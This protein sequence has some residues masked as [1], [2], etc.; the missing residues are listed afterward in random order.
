MFATTRLFLLS[1][2]ASTAALADRAPPDTAA[3]AAQVAQ[4][5]QA[6][7]RDFHAHPELGN[8]EFRTAELVAG[9]LRGLGL[10]VRTGIAHT[11]V[12]GVL[13]GGRPGPRLALRADMDAL[14]VTERVDLPFASK[15]VAEYRGRQT[16]VMHACGH[17]AHTAILMGVAQALTSIRTKLPGEVMFIFQPAEE[18]PPDGEE[19]GAEMML[20]EGLF[21][22]FQPDAVLGLHVIAG[23]PSDTIAVRPGPF[24]AA[25]DSFRIRVIGRQSHGSRPWDGIDPIVAAADII[26]SAQALVSRQTDLTRAP[27]VLSFGAINGGIRSNIIPESVELIGTI[28]TFEPDMRDK[29][30]AG[31][32]GVAEHVA[33]AHGA[34]VETQ[35]PDEQGYPVTRNDPALTARL[36]P[37]LAR[38]AGGKVIEIPPI[39][40]SED[41]SFYGQHAPAL[42][43]FVGATPPGP[44]VRSAPTNH[45]PEFFVDEAAL[46]LGTR[47]LLQASLDFLSG[48]AGP[49]AR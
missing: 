7:R 25:G 13:R 21:R 31:L 41:F 22:D 49:A 37:S 32:R 45:S 1:L 43:F 23:M 10:E 35:I 48:G 4:P 3:L 14:P 12:A 8:R 33:A 19:G 44:D 17:D 15:V 29:V 47:A 38:A 30:F 20:A 5:V 36:R 26:S 6:W 40:G 39:T 24:M 18:G 16:G 46:P 11:G 2:L 34:R 27:V 9:H 42:F 28:R